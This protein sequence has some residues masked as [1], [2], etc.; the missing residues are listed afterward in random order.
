MDTWLVAAHPP[1]QE[2]KERKG[3]V[4]SMVERQEGGAVRVRCPEQS[5]FWD[6]GDKM[7]VFAV[8]VALEVY[9]GKW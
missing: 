8:A 4:A 3:C 2:G 5:L 9:H 1:G 7:I 6:T